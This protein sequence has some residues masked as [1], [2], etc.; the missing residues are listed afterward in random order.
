MTALAVLRRRVAVKALHPKWV[1]IGS[2]SSGAFG[3]QSEKID[4]NQLCLALEELRSKV[5]AELRI[6]AIVIAQ[7]GHRD[8][9][10][11]VGAERR[12]WVAR[13]PVAGRD[14]SDATLTFWSGPGVDLLPS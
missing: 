8:H 3:C 4:P 5:F 7:I 13:G 1:T 10:W 14:R 2:R 6:S 9:S 11:R 12:A